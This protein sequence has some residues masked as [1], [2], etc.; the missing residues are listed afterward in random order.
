MATP[1]EITLAET[2]LDELVRSID[3]L[4]FVEYTDDPDFEDV[5]P[6]AAFNYLMAGKVT[7]TPPQE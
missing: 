3:F 1:E 5:D 7:L 4:N 6:E 2:V